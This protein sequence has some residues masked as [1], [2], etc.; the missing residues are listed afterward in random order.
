MGWVE[1]IDGALVWQAQA[2]GFNVTTGK[3]YQLDH[4]QIK[5]PLLCQEH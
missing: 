5:N 3:N 1:L 2:P 4:I